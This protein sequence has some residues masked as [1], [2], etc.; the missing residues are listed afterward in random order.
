MRAVALHSDVLVVTSALLQTNC[1]IVRGSRTDGERERRMGAAPDLLEE[2]FVIDSPILPDELEALVALVAQAGF[3]EPSAL[4]ATH[5]DWDH[6]LGRLAFPNAALGVAEDT[7]A[8]LGKEPGRAQ[9][10]LRDFDESL[11]IKRPRPLALGSIQA[12]PV[13]GN[14]ELGGQTLELHA[15]T[16]HTSDG[17]AVHL[18]WAKVLAVG[19][20]CS[21]VEIPTL[22][23]SGTVA[24]YL[25]TLER[26]R[27]LLEASELIVPGHGPVLDVEHA[28][29]VLE[30]DIAY[31]SALAASP[32]DAQLPHTRSTKVQRQAHA[33]NVAIVS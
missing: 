26:L 2:T 11:M 30:E 8:R 17:M 24:E 1:L 4:L 3:T 14:C 15:T 25:G 22:G 12:L 33:R 29:R 19:D 18:R 10:E 21:S 32:H 7:A 31:L 5:G 9:R 27:P 28:L 6:L 16:G 13:P 20:Y 23:G